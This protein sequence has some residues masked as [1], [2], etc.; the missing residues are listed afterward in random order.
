MEAC[1]GG[2]QCTI[3]N[4]SKLPQ[5]PRTMSFRQHS[6]RI[7]SCTPRRYVTDRTSVNFSA[8]RNSEVYKWVYSFLPN[9]S[10]TRFNNFNF[11]FNVT[12]SSTR[13]HHLRRAPDLHPQSA[14]SNL[15]S[16]TLSSL[17]RFTFCQSLPNFYDLSFP[18]KMEKHATFVA[19]W[20][21]EAIVA[22]L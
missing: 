19:Q 9:S 5:C 16:V 7:S 22:H 20:L 18:M 4:V 21:V 12:S 13:T 8:D 1:V 2:A 14:G 6:L 3:R 10:G 15:S 11:N 17:T